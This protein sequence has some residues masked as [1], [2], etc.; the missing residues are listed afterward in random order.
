MKKIER[1]ESYEK[2][3]IGAP[4][5]RINK[6]FL[7]YTPNESIFDRWM[8]MSGNSEKPV[9]PTPVDYKNEYLTIEA[10]DNGA[11][12][13]FVMFDYASVIGGQTGLTQPLTIEWS[14][15][16]KKWNT[17]TANIIALSIDDITYTYTA[18]YGE[19]ITELHKGDKIYLKG[20]NPTYGFNID[21]LAKT[22][23]HMIHILPKEL[24]NKCQFSVLDYV[25]DD[26][27]ATRHNVSGNIMSLIYGDDFKNKTVLSEENAGAF[28]GLF[29]LMCGIGGYNIYLNSIYHLFLPA[30]TLS[31]GCYSY[32]F[33]GCT[34]ITSVPTNMLPATA[35]A[36]NCY[37]FMFG[38]CTSLTTA[39]E[40]PATI[41]AE[42]CYRSMFNSCSSIVSAPALP[43]TVLLDSCYQEMFEY[44]ESLT[45]APVL[46]AEILVSNCYRQ[47]F[48]HCT[49][50]NS[51]KC[52]ATTDIGQNNSTSNWVGYVA[53][54]GIFEKA[55]GVTWPSGNNGVP[56]GWISEI[57]EFIPDTQ[58]TTENYLTFNIEEDG[59]FGLS[60]ISSNQTLYLSKN[61]TDWVT[62]NTTTGVKVYEVNDG[63]TI[64]V[65]GILTGNNSTVN[66]TNFAIT[67]N[68]SMS[69]NVNSI[70]NYENID[71]PIYQYCGHK[72]FKNCVGLVD[73]SEISLTTTIL[74]GF[75][76]CN[77]FDGCSNLTTVP[78]DL[79]P[80]TALTN[81]CYNSMFYGCSSLTT[82]PALP[83][84][85][86]ASGCYS[87][88]FHGCNNLVVAP[89]LPATALTQYCYQ[90][91]FSNCIQLKA[92]PVLPATL[93]EH[94]CYKYMFQNCTSLTSVSELPATTLRG[95]CYYGM[96]EDCTSITNIRQ[97]QLPATILVSG[98]YEYMFNRCTSLETVPSDLLPATALTDSCYS[99][100]FQNCT[101]LA[102]APSLPATKLANE[103]YF[104][105]FNGCRSLTTAPELPATALTN[106]CYGYMFDRCTSLTTAPE[107]PA[108]TLTSSCY[109]K[110]FEGCSG[111]NYIKCLAINGINQNNSTSNW[112][113]GVQ[114]NEGT[115]IKP[116]GTS[117]TTGVNGI[118]EGWTVEEV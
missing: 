33:N 66:Y 85:K 114:T 111:L 16:K 71:S 62:L 6:P 29:S 3:L 54:I 46:S 50:L 5:L 98:C 80:A 19:P 97:N 20:N 27:P 53:P 87:N 15:D 26:T 39:P 25:D 45:T 94:S 57:S 2:Q 81:D 56:D 99:C 109:N 28:Y 65:C 8:Y 14:L 100:M 10:L 84:T 118:P 31:R 38:N 24:N 104:S 7:G 88:M 48:Y 68:V 74:T 92:A 112:V 82:A 95:S 18:D 36:T 30:T 96:F 51:I 69:G 102:A 49:N 47:M 41:L 91:M 115:F 86:L 76:Y 116:T 89:E 77:M 93:L 42:G 40:L 13:Y 9:P 70:W 101:S 107:L 117:W 21:E 72:L 37:N 12:L 58:L 43:A 32:I 113:H 79:L 22:C 59:Y 83:A 44:C 52:Y 4:D 105:M 78:Q 67:G 11:N 23:F 106:Y 61:L 75:C 1:P 73:L 55:D 60:N 64:Y 90:Y 103:C 110:M 17:F 108:T 35:L 34:K 63:E